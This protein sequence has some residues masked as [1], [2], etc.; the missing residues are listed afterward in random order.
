MTL[1]PLQPCSLDELPG[2]LPGVLSDG[3]GARAVLA[4]LGEHPEQTLAMLRP[5][6]PVTEPDA[7]VV[8]ATSGSS[9]VPKGVV[10]SRRALLAAAEAA[11]QRLGAMT[12]T[13]VLPVGYVAGL[14]VMVRAHVA[15][16]PVR[17]AR[18]D[19]SDLEPV[20]GANAISIVPTQL[21]RAMADRGMLA[22]L[23]RYDAI[24]LG[25]APVDAALLA[26]ARGRGLNLITT[27]GMSETCGG[28]V[29]DGEP[30]PGVD[31]GIAAAEQHPTTAAQTAPTTAAEPSPTT[32]AEPVEAP[33]GRITLSGE[34][35]FSG[36]RLAPELTAATLAGRTVLTNDRGEWSDGRLRVLG[37][38]DDVVISGGVNVDLA[39]VQRAVE[40][41]EPGTS[42]VLATPDPEWGSR[43]TL[44]SCSG[45]G[46]A[47]WHDRL[48]G[49]LGR[50]ALP[51]RIVP[52]DVLP[53]TSSGKID[54]QALL[55]ELG[56]E[57]DA[58]GNGW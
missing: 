3:G 22:S 42:L 20:P 35:A 2:L 54:R 58:R 34:M 29:W 44:V 17:F 19:L 48:R 5:D 45:H 18:A 30:L 38:M 21:F 8:V 47:W 31:V 32:A 49:G 50:A 36:Y 4:P 55:R 46:L 28:C 37:R 6:L 23:A 43:V 39:A 26:E 7:A 33:S 27:Y 25:G 16:R 1:R 14:M 41:I 11:Q 57:G 10:L 24:L 13:C 53:R 51:R 15:G 56:E 9:G 52:V 12:W 40:A